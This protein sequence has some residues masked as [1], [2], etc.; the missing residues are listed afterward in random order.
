MKIVGTTELRTRN[1]GDSLQ[2]VITRSRGWME[3]AFE[4][5]LIGG[6]LFY[7]WRQGS[8]TLV[9]FVVLGTVAMVINGIQRRETFLQVSECGIVTR[10]S[11]SWVGKGVTIPVGEI[12]SMGWSG[13][14]DGDDGGVYVMCGYSQSWVLPGAT[15]EHG[16]MVISAIQDRFPAFPV[17][18]RT[19]TS[20]LFGDDSGITTLHLSKPMK[21]N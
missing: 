1:L 20:L 7:A 12:S 14:G 5:L 18:D 4:V 2:F 3:I 11:F 9:I 16:R 15:E 8:T 21:K 13:G 19:P 17:V 6:F 10:N